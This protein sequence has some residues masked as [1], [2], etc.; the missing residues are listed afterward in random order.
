MP[1]I[2]QIETRVVEFDAL[3][4]YGGK[5]VPKGRPRTWRYPWV[6]LRA[7]DGTEGHSTAYGPHGDGPA[8]AEVIHEVYA[9]VLLGHDATDTDGLWQKLTAKTR[10]LYHLSDALVGVLDV[11]AW[12][13]RGKLAGQSVAGLL[14][15]QRTHVPAYRSSHLFEPTIQEICDEVLLS[16]ADGFRGF[17]LQFRDGLARDV[18]RLRAVR[19]TVDA[20]FPL[21]QDSVAGYGLT[22]ALAL[23]RVLDELDFLW[24]EEPVS[25]YDTAGLIA[26]SKQL[27]TPILAGETLPLAALGTFAEATRLPMLRGDVL[28][29]NG[30]TGLHRAFGLARERGVNLEIHSAGSPLLDVA[31]LHV[32]CANQNGQFLELHHPIFHL[33]LLDTPLKI[34]ARGQV[35]VPTGPGLGATIDWAWV[36]AHTIAR[37]VT[38]Y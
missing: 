27:K 36:D 23:G 14:G 4:R 34:D 15:Q 10:H 6:T 9:E 31:N 20:D 22:D 17:K 30:I 24:Y 32:A 19:E 2:T 12:D 5:P 18:P 16:R 25:D 28:I 13:L 38:Q 35:H 7:D 21:M 37:R 3:P 33:G 26:L 1:I 29:K 8:M 11:A